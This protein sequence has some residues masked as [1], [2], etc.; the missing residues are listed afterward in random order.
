[1]TEN[2]NAPD[3]NRS[4]SSNNWWLKRADHMKFTEECVMCSEKNVLVKML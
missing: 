2:H 3:L 1:M 4:L